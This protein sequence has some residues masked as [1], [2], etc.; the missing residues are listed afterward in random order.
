MA[1]TLSDLLQDIYSELGQLSVGIAT[2]GGN[3]E[4]A[5]DG[6]LSAETDVIWRNTAG[7]A[8]GQ[9]YSSPL[10]DSTYVVFGQDLYLGLR[11]SRDKAG[12][13]PSL[14]G[15]EVYTPGFS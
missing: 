3:K 13:S 2:G 14:N 15:N 9:Q 8:V 10:L 6:C 1:Y 12:S 4:S 5:Y 11:S 7:A